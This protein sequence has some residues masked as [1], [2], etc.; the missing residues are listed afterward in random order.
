VCAGLR[1]CSRKSNLDQYDARTPR[2][3]KCVNPLDFLV[4]RTPRRASLTTFSVPRV[5]R[6]RVFAFRGILSTYWRRVGTH[7][8]S[9][10][11]AAFSVQS[12]MPIFGLLTPTGTPSH[13]FALRGRHTKSVCS[14]R[15]A[16]G[17]VAVR[18]ASPNES[19]SAV[20]EA[21][22]EGK[23]RRPGVA[24]STDD[25]EDAAAPEKGPNVNSDGVHPE[26]AS[27][28]SLAYLDTV[29]APFVALP[30]VSDAPGEGKRKAPGVVEFGGESGG[31][32]AL[33]PPKG[34]KYGKGQ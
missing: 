15:T 11:R 7:A 5:S 10:A 13:V 33:E 32:P 18:R 20:S 14:V 24:N 21:P 12:L 34:G 30:D 31:K 27:P 25:W 3:Q 29:T 1:D 17:N 9:G 6:T 16:R 19:V 2:G 28:V 26:D 23:R 4:W 8:R 22:G